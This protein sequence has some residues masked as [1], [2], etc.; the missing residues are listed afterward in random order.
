MKSNTI[1][2]L[3]PILVSEMIFLRLAYKSR[4]YK[5]KSFKHYHIQCY[6]VSFRWVKFVII[7]KY[8]FY[9]YLMSLFV[10]PCLL[11]SIFPWPKSDSIQR[12]VLARIN[13]FL[14]LKEMIY[15]SA[16]KKAIAF[17]YGKKGWNNSD[18]QVRST[19]IE[20]FHTI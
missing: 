11:C 15:E 1:S 20:V 19:K 2:N 12:H 8:Y 5:I 6:K 14:L 18:Y 10:Q 9:E 7:K 13:S 4:K 3:Y 16:N 17:F